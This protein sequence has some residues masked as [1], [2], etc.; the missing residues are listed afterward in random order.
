MSK[1]FKLFNPLA[2]IQ[3]E[4]LE[5]VFKN[6][7]PDGKLEDWHS[8]ALCERLNELERIIRPDSPERFSLFVVEAFDTAVQLAYLKSLFETLKPKEEENNGKGR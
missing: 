1:P 3:P 5:E 7:N 2:G 8:K 6:V 4:E